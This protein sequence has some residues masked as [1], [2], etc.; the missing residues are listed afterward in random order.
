[1]SSARDI[2]RR[3]YF[4]QFLYWFATGLPLALTVLLLQA[5]GLDLFEI[6]IVM[7]IY[8][9]VIVLL[10]LP[11]GGLADAI[12]RKP[13]TLMAY[14]FITIYSLILF[15]AFSFEAFVLAYVIYGIGR[16]LSSG[17]LD[18]WFLDALKQ[19][20]EHVEIQPRLATATTFILLGLGLG[21]LLGGAIASLFAFLPD[22]G[23]AILTP[24][25]VPVL[26]AAV[27]KLLLLIAGG[28]LIHEDR[29]PFKARG[30]MAGV[31]EVPRII[32]TGFSLVRR[33]LILMLMLGGTLVNGLFVIGL[34]NLWQP[35]FDT[36]LGE[37]EG[38][39]AMLGFIMGATFLVGIGGNLISTWLSRA[40]NKRYALVAL[41][42]QL[43]K[44]GGLIAL[45][46]IFNPFVAAIAFWSCYFAIGVGNS[47][48]A[49]LV[50]E[51][52][53]SERR[54][55][56][57]SIFSL[58]AFVG[59]ITGSVILGFVAQNLSITAAW[60][61][62]AAVVLLSGWLYLRADRERKNESASSVNGL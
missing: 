15:F 50:N 44:A 24:S 40:L 6:G 38:E 60:L 27:L 29:E 20:D 26:V 8:S 46:L 57:M 13:V 17:A 59:S 35:R 42:G 14:G 25:A 5:R 47:P 55:S 4:I 31:R 28:M 3:Y 43:I 52:I 58:M 36:L 18:A 23:T 33:N 51:E 62:G 22:D 41:I 30:V 56:M 1:V 61:M 34:E 16:A 19:R 11:T 7:A 2:E 39:R 48:Q 53:P 37:R 21:T 54:S 9:V 10:E 12:G 45:A 49:T 32:T